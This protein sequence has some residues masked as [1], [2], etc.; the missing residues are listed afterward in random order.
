MFAIHKKLNNFERTA[1]KVGDL[2]SE[3]KRRGGRHWKIISFWSK[4]EEQ[5]Q[6]FGINHI[7]RM[8]ENRHAE[9]DASDVSSVSYDPLESA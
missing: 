2:R 8:C 6:A 5:A 1:V 3:G 9:I 7:L 4:K